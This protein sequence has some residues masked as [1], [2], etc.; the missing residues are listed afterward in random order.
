M[1][2]Y[3]SMELMICVAARLL[4]NGST[5]GVGTGAWNSYRVCELAVDLSKRVK[6]KSIV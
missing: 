2:D 1:A 4:K 6:S 5:V 3:N